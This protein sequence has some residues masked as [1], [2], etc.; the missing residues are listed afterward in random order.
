MRTVQALYE[1]ARA[2]FL[3]RARRYSFLITLA[4]T[5]Y[6]GYVFLPSNHARYVTMQISGHRGVYS[7]AY[8]GSL[9]ALLT[10]VF[11]S[12]AGF[13][14]VKNA[15][16]RDI[17]TRVGQILA[18]TPLTKPLYVFG[19]ALSNFAVLSAIVA[20][21]ALAA[22]IMQM[23]RREE[24]LLQLS[25]L[26][27]PFLFITLP[28][29]AVVASTAILFE[30]VRWLRGGLG[31]VLYFPLWLAA[32]MVLVV[33]YDA[34]S[35]GQFNDLLGLGTVIPSLA[36]ACEA[37]FPGCTGSTFVFSAGLTFKSPGE[38]W[39]LET[40]HWQGVHWTLQTILGRLIWIAVA[41]AL[42]AL[43]AVFF[44]RFDS[45]R[46]SA[47]EPRPKFPEAE[48]ALARPPATQVVFSRMDPVVQQF[49][50]AAIVMAELRLALKGLSRWWYLVAVIMLLG[51]LVS[52]LP[53][54]RYW[55][56]GAWIWPVLIWSAMGTRETRQGTRQLVFSVAHPLRRQLPACWL[57]GVIVAAL[58]GG[59]TALRLLFAQRSIALAAWTLGALFIPTLALAL[60]VWSCSSKLFEVVYVLLW[61]IGPVSRVPLFDY[62][63]VADSALRSDALLRLVM[64]TLMLATL[65]FVG[66]KR[67]IRV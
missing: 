15:L 4:I 31:N 54:S 5:L 23:I 66:R 39:D 6:V 32:V 28:V 18:T 45:A 57:A 26:L 44:D 48:M 62:V 60:G 21:M 10:S 49:S 47:K 42:A 19:K 14:L 9:V 22:G 29:M 50:F 30:T 3:E 61:Y 34:L 24:M 8:V 53:M 27:A 25:D 64:C 2:D 52:P 7:S 13:Y 11:L 56:I 63:G 67:Q 58:T 40:F 20:V 35:R 17:Q 41:A 36:A 43:A 51:E 33:R 46:E 65:A 37:T 12:L 1:L 55:L 59:A 16:D 38:R